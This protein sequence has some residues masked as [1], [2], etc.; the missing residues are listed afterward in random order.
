[1]KRETATKRAAIRSRSSRGNSARSSSRAE[2]AALGD[3]KGRAV[4][5]DALI[6][7]FEERGFIH[8]SIS[9]ARAVGLDA[10]EAALASDIALG[11]MRHHVTIEHVLS[12]VA[13]YEPKRADAALKALLYA[14]A[15]QVVW[16]DRIPNFAAVDEGVKLARRVISRGAAGM[17]NAV[18]RRLCAAITER[19]ARWRAHD[20]TL[21]RTGW[22]SAC[23]FSRPVLPPPDGE[24]LVRHIAAAAGERAGRLAVLAERYGMEAAAQIAWAGSAIPPIVV[25]RNR[26]RIDEEEFARRVGVEM[27]RERRAAA[28]PMSEEAGHGVECEVAAQDTEFEI[29]GDVAFVSAGAFEG[30][31]SLLREGRAYVQDSTAAEVVAMLEARPGER[32]LDLCAAPG[33]K[34]AALAIQMRDR[35]EIVAADVDADRLR[36]VEENA[37]RLGLTC[38][39]TRGASS[40]SD[41]GLFDAVLVDAPCSNSGV[42]AR[43]PE[44]R[45]RLDTRRLRSLGAIQAELLNR[46]GTFVKA[47]G[48]LVYGTCSIE[49]EENEAI[50]ARFLRDRPEW[51]VTAEIRATPRWGARPSEWRDGGFAALLRRAG[52]STCVNDGSAAERAR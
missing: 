37:R 52:D 34:T 49:P 30:G 13:R 47:G 32:V 43:R 2:R 16:M 28:R 14:S 15:Y 10:R 8:E 20:A 44:A 39:A 35:G 38:V 6:A 24:S 31:A 22:T 12:A 50:V 42:L 19:S 18:L 41:V 36:Q 9:N 51:S 25:R 29:A 17:V 48:R 4:A 33:G 7:A 45:L 26:L 21:I 1:M 3:L 46:A 5:V 23:R 40:L 27:G 11:A